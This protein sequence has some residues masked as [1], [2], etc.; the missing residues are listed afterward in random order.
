M[1][2]PSVCDRLYVVVNPSFVYIVAC[3]I[4]R[5]NFFKIMDQCVGILGVSVER[6]FLSI[7]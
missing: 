6:M 1:A 5:V 3:L 2:E 4:V 7:G